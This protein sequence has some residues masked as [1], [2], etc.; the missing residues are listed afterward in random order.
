MLEKGRGKRETGVRPRG[1]VKSKLEGG[2]LTS[3]T[4]SRA[5]LRPT[6]LH[7]HTTSNKDAI[8]RFTF[9]SSTNH[10]GKVERPIIHNSNAQVHAL[11]C[12][13]ICKSLITRRKKVMSLI[14][15]TFLWSVLKTLP[16]SSAYPRSAPDCPRSVVWQPASHPRWGSSF[17]CRGRRG[18]RWASGRWTC[19]LG[20]VHVSQNGSIAVC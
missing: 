3:R 7:V 18:L 13:A 9:V 17:S 19:R 1:K 10:L 15:A 16:S 5:K 2:F 12:Y 8:N 20:S 11:L 4:P 14:K 6:S